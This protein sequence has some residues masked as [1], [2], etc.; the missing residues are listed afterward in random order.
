MNE[1]KTSSNENEENFAYSCASRLQTSRR[2]RSYRFKPNKNDAENGTRKKNESAIKD[3]PARKKKVWTITITKMG[4]MN[5]MLIWNI[6]KRIVNGHNNNR[7]RTQNSVF[8][9]SQASNRKNEK[10]NHLAIVS[11]WRSARAPINRLSIKIT[12]FLFSFIVWHKRESNQLIG[13]RFLCTRFSN[14]QR[15]MTAAGQKRS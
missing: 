5:A 11:T 14:S 15:T 12:D 3:G 6:F 4:L 7:E 8:L 10:K 9:I 2:C 1:M 13:Q